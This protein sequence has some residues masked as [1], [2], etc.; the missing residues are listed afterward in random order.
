MDMK[1]VPSVLIAEDNDD[2]LNILRGMLAQSGVHVIPAING[3]EALNILDNPQDN[4][5]PD[6]LLTDIQM[7]EMSGIE[8][9]REIRNRENFTNLPIIAMSSG[10]SEI[11]KSALAAGATRAVSK[12]FFDRIIET[13]KGYLDGGHPTYTQF[14]L[15]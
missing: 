4:S 10:S 6:L 8:L 13:I 12:S 9:I 7:P 1:K 2:M 15:P 5:L 11:I 3:R 14:A